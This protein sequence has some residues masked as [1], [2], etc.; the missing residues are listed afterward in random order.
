MKCEIFRL[1]YG[2]IKI[3]PSIHHHLYE[4]KIKES[5]Y[6]LCVLFVCVCAMRVMELLQPKALLQKMCH[7]DTWIIFIYI[8]KLQLNGIYGCKSFENYGFL[9]LLEYAI[10]FIYSSD[11]SHFMLKVK[12]CE[13]C[14]FVW[15]RILPGYDVR[16]NKLFPPYR[17]EKLFWEC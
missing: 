13:I 7:R 12:T 15:F 8:Y 9:S 11:S 4:W 5:F 3:L 10:S 14:S 16:E 1:F 2:S 6:F 17:N